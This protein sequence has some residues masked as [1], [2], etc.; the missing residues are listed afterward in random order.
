MKVIVSYDVSVVSANG[1]RR[2]RRVAKIC[3]N[4][5]LRVQN[6]VFECELDWSQLISMKASLLKEIDLKHDSLRF[7]NL[8][9]KYKQKIEHYGVKSTPDLKEDALIY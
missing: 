1:R 3:M 5:G 4:H 8:G 9:N 2:L 6:S 7:Y